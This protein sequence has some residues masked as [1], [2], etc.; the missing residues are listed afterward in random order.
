MWLDCQMYVGSIHQQYTYITSHV[1]K[2]NAV[3]ISWL[4]VMNGLT[5]F[6]RKSF[7]KNQV[8]TRDAHLVGQHESTE[9]SK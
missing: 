8:R 9:K 4:R 3:I 5:F 2:S 6:S 7:I 1:G